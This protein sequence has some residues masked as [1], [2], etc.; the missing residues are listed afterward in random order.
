M[1][2]ARLP[3][4]QSDDPL[5]GGHL[6]LGMSKTPSGTTRESSRVIVHVI[7]ALDVAH[8]KYI[9]SVV[10]SESPISNG[11]TAVGGAKTKLLLHKIRD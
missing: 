2:G 8:C 5:S 9:G 6:A 4:T 1:I 10:A 11:L 3:V 7:C